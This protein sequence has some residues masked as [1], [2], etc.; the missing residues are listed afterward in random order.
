MLHD[1]YDLSDLDPVLKFHT[2]YFPVNEVCSAR[3]AWNKV[4]RADLDHCHLHTMAA[5]HK[6]SCLLIVEAIACQRSKH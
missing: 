5:C 4:G 1:G 3:Y 2:V 6:L